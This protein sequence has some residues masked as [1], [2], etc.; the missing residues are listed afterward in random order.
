MADVLALLQEGLTTLKSGQ[1]PDVNF[2]K[3]LVS[4][5]SAAVVAH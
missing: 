3:V 2:L 5:V 4:R 1:V